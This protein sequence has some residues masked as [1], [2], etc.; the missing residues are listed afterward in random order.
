MLVMWYEKMLSIVN[1]TYPISI[2]MYSVSS[3]IWHSL[4]VI[5]F[6]IFYW[7]EK[8][9]VV[10]F[11]FPVQLTWSS[12]TGESVCFDPKIK[13]RVPDERNGLY[14]IDTLDPDMVYS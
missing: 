8:F 1:P 13:I 7:R 12:E 5:K 2:M 6:S 11:L 10:P 14:A 4:S 9:G 3:E